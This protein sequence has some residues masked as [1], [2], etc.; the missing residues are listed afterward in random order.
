[1][2]PSTNCNDIKGQ[3]AQ[4]EAMGAPLLQHEVF[5]NSISFLDMILSKLPTPPN[6]RI[7]GKFI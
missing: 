3:G 6:W 7:D 2:S 4:W 1:M 5:S